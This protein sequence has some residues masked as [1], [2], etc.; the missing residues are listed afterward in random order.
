ME[1]QL[2]IPMPVIGIQVVVRRQPRY[3]WVVERR[4][5]RQDQGW[6]PAGFWS[7]LEHREAELVAAEAL[8]QGWYVEPL[9]G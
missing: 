8:D 5:L 1:E 6:Q 2:S 9:D 3:G 4:V 7:Q